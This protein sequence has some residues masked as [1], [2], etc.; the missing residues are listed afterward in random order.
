MD[1]CCRLHELLPG[2]TADGDATL[3]TGVMEIFST[4]DLAVTAVYTTGH[5]GIDVREIKARPR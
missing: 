3:T 1:D 4:V 2:S 5:G